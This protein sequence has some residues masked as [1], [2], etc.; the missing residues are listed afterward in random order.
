MA[1]RI[2]NDQEPLEYFL[3]ENIQNV[4]WNRWLPGHGLL[5]YHVNEVGN[6]VIGTYTHINNTA[7]EPGMAIVPADSVCLS[8]YIKANS[9][10]YRQSQKGDPFPGTS[11]VT[12]LN[13]NMG[14]PNFYWYAGT[15][16]P[17]P[18]NNKYHKVDKALTS[19]KED[20][21][22]ITFNFINGYATGIRDIKQDQPACDNMIYSISGQPVGKGTSSMQPGI[23]IR[24]GK[25][26]VVK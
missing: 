15:Q 7:G 11:M 16:P 9:T 6:S 4:G 22:A 21:G 19:I 14:I 25:K 8:S 3:L 5:V 20:N 23:Y 13:D 2:Q 18:T 17:S 1:Y 10:L 12:A 24:N 26:F